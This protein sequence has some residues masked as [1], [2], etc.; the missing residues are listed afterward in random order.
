MA[1]NC[2]ACDDLRQNAPDFVQN[3]VTTAVCNSLK[4]D[5]GLNAGLSPK[6]TDCEDMEDVLDCLIGNLDDELEAYDVC[7]WKD[8]MHKF[9]PNLYNTLGAMVCAMCGQWTAIHKLECLV[10][11]LFK[12]ATFRVGEDPSE[13]SYVVP[14]DGVSYWERLGSDQ[15]TSDIYVLYVAGG[16]GRGGGSLRFHTK[17]WTDP[18]AVTDIRG[19]NTTARKGNAVWGSKGDTVSGN[20]LV[21]EI[22]IKKSQY[23][24]LKSIY[25]GLG[26]E[27]NNGGMHV[28][29]TAYTAGDWAPGQHGS[30]D[31][32]TG[33][34]SKDGF[35]AGHKV[36]DG[37]IY[38]QLR[39]SWIDECVVGDTTI[40]NI[41]PRYWLGMRFSQDDI[42]C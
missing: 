36:P 17:D 11:Y 29:A 24:E 41:T 12:G 20:E 1:T 10:N 15:H 9:I 3:G 37:W 8:F 42:D 23:P 13:G 5:T 40:A 27:T 26:Q 34:P 31:E 16:L 7:D 14:G 2:G 25:G 22:R 39:C 38:L 18:K 35:S 21:Y 28:I 4:N 30:C 19:N 33:A 32:E 6:H